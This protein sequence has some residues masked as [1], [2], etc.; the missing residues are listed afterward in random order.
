MHCEHELYMVYPSAVLALAYVIIVA[1]LN[2][3]KNYYNY[4]NHKLGPKRT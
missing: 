3:F 1:Q 2:G 4:L